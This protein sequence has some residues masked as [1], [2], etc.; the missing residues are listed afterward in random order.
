MI[1]PCESCE[2]VSLSHALWVEWWCG[3]WWWYSKRDR[4]RAD[5]SPFYVQY[6]RSGCLVGSMTIYGGMGR[7]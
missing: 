7:V 3:V 6:C 1:V 4:M 5:R 2:R